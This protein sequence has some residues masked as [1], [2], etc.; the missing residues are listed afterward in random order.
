M[1]KILSP[2]KF[3]IISVPRSGSSAIVDALNQHPAIIA[4][5]EIYHPDLDT[6]LLVEFRDYLKKIRLNTDSI[7][8]AKEVYAC[9]NENQEAI[10]FK[11]FP[12]QDDEALAWLL[13][14]PDIIKI[15][16]IRENMLASYSSLKISEEINYWNDKSIVENLN[17][18]ITFDN[19][20]FSSYCSWYTYCF[21]NYKKT[22]LNS[23]QANFLTIRYSPVHLMKEINNVLKYLGIDNDDSC[24][25]RYKKLNT[26]NI[27]SR[28]T[29]PDEVQNCLASLSK[30]EWVV[31]N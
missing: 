12:G 18:Q 29:N 28:F 24:E 7:T 2:K 26:K 16:L 17:H 15:F 10:G 23:N 20:E 13:D 31:E 25:I 3:V 11:I 30:S 8:Y 1:S 21:E 4:H 19:T 9:F 27:I 5:G 14:N 22:L 6:H